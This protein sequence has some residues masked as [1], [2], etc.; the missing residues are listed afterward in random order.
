VVPSDA[1]SYIEELGAQ[2]EALVGE[3][4][5]AADRAAETFR[6]VEN[7][8]GA[9]LSAERLARLADTASETIATNARG[10]LYPVG[11]SP[12]VAIDWC[13]GV[14]AIGA[15]MSI[16][17]IRDR[18][19]TRFPRVAEIPNRPGLDMLIERLG[20][21]WDPSISKYRPRDTAFSTTK[22]SSRATTEIGVLPPDQFGERLRKSHERFLALTARPRFTAPAERRLANESG[23][24]HVNLD[25]GL[26]RHMKD[27]AA[28][29]EAHWEAILRLDQDGPE[30]P[31]WIT[32]ITVAAQAAER[33]RD[34]LLAT[35]G[36]VLVSRLGL[37]RRYDCLNIIDEIRRQLAS[38]NSDP[39]LKGLWALVPADSKDQ[40]PMVDGVPIPV[41]DENDWAHIPTEWIRS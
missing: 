34:E 39:Q 17:E 8:T 38:P 31:N 40:Q 37:L 21:E 32:L 41:I 19:Q 14:L 24:M 16:D 30:G 15:E 23:V 33:L 13:A 20:L 29:N 1:L 12:D 26:I 28:A 2:A 10:E 35:N 36:T 6:R 5:I 3:Q 18:V 25:S 27:I 9:A 4:P 7:P 22:Y 11:M